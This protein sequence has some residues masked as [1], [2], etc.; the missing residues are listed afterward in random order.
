MEPK[1]NCPN[2]FPKSPNMVYNGLKCWIKR[3]EELASFTAI[4]KRHMEMP[5]PQ[6][7][8]HMKQQLIKLKEGWHKKGWME[9]VE[10]P[11]A[12]GNPLAGG[13]YMLKFRPKEE[14]R[15]R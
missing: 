2:C 13:H 12:F 4:L 11:G 7:V 1:P 8:T 5:T 14:V 6:E 3:N 9:F 10:V 15:G